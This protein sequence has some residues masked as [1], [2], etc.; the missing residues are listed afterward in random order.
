VTD[1]SLVEK[2]LGL[3]E[4]VVDSHG[5]GEKR[6]QQV[7]M[8][9]SV[10]NAIEN[11]ERLLVQAGTGVGKSL[12]Y[13]VPAV[14]S[15]KRIVVSTATNQLSEQLGR[16]DMPFLN[17]IF[18]EY[19][20][21]NLSYS[22]V[23]GRSNYVCQ[24][25][26]AELVNLDG[27]SDA[28][29]KSDQE[30][31]LL[32]DLAEVHRSRNENKGQEVSSI[33]DWV[34]EDGIDGDK[35]SAPAVSEEIWRTVSSTNAE[36]P[37]R[38]ACPFGQTCFA[39]LA[40]DKARKSNIVIT[41]HALV[42]TD[43]S[44]QGADPGVIIGPRDVV[45]F[46]EMHELDSYLS[47]AWGT[48]LTEKVIEESA[49]HARRAIDAD[50]THDRDLIEE[51]SQYGEKVAAI[52]EIL[53]AGIIKEWDE[54]VYAV[55]RGIADTA[56]RLASTT[57]IKSEESG[58]TESTRIKNVVATNSLVALFDATTMLLDSSDEIVKWI[59]SERDKKIF[60]AAPLRVGPRLI[61]ALNDANMTMVATSAT[62]TVGGKFDIPVRNFAL[63]EVVESIPPTP[64]KA[65]DV[66]TPFDYPRQGILYIPKPDDFP[67]PVGADRFEHTE[68][69]L[70]F[71]VEMVKA[72]DGRLL[73]LS[74]TSEGAR[75]MA[76]RLYD[77]VPHLNVIS[78][79]DGA[80]G[81]IA[82]A[83]KNDEQSVLCA[84]MG[85][86]HGLNVPGKSLSG[87]LIDKIPFKP[88]DDPL[89][90]ARKNDADA[91]GQNGFMDIY[92]AQA[93]VFLA[94]G[95][96]RA[97]RNTS[98]RAVVAALDTRLRT[99]AYGKSMLKSLP[100]MWQTGDKAIALASLK[101]LV[102]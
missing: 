2:S 56:R 45:I 66:G 32:P 3:L 25:K 26:V 9:E 48:T 50:K 76:E 80:A 59:A 20:G 5:S 31:L 34:N 83:F 35:T 44:S 62:I 74:T 63:T 38:N 55:L 14:C 39:E 22:V 13:L 41:N 30:F 54:S 101:S 88:M 96:G 43:I 7:T 19:F 15:G 57:G 78:H 97:I 4:A 75:K 47:E 58:I 91:R 40:R 29:K 99:K 71:L 93:N 98:D 8:A 1:E 65:L 90:V 28:D 36:C 12:G 60:K 49:R 87:L 23:K 42:A 53:D 52:L 73:A 24:R 46:D 77:E 82:D 16:I 95:V 102:S 61:K 81:K 10:A 89:M 18:K 21:Y 64:Y 72:G 37:G 79:L 94:Q 92:A 33:V 27:D 70:E 68:A 6:P 100:P 85:M 69:T 67:A 17:K 84:T 51:L 86:W 11:K